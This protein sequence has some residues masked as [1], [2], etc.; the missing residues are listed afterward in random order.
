MVGERIRVPSALTSM[1]F[2]YMRCDTRFLFPTGVKLH[3]I[4]IQQ[5]GSICILIV[6]MLATEQVLKRKGEEEANP[7]ILFRISMSSLTQYANLMIEEKQ[8]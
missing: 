8:D 6:A 5:N 4:S 1:M 3:G 7:G 2:L